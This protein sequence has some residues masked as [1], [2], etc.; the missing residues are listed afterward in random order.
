MLVVH[1]VNKNKNSYYYIF[2]E[3]GSYEDKSVV[4][5]G[6]TWCKLIRSHSKKKLHSYIPFFNHLF[7]VRNKNLRNKNLSLIILHLY[8]HN[9]KHLNMISNTFIQFLYTPI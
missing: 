3:K 9:I 7:I 1:N 2:L 4:Y 8:I 6:L 5:N